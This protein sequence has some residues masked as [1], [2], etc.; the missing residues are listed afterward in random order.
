MEGPAKPPACP[1]SP[2]KRWIG[3]DDPIGPIPHICVICVR[4]RVG[5]SI[6]L[7]VA[8]HEY[9]DCG[10]EHDVDT[11]GLPESKCPMP[12][13]FKFHSILAPPRFPAV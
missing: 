11:P 7:V 8:G 9:I 2:R 5:D 3:L 1:S 12:S 13:P 10:Y 4:G 6:G